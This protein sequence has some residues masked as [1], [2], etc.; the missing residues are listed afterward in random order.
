MEDVLSAPSL[1]LGLFLGMLD[2]SIVAT[3]LFTI[4]TEFEALQSVNWV[5]LAYTLSFLGCAVLFARLADII[6]RRD[7]FILSYVTFVAFS[8]GCGFAR[9]LEQLIALRTLQGMGGSGLYSITMIIFP[10]LTPPRLKK[11][12]ASLVGIVIALSGVFG[13]ILGG[14]LTYYASWRWVFWIK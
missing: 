13:P 7:A 12:I 1:C 14:V 3:S 5:A 11:F 10:E 8:I 2:S 4:G 6:G 9:N